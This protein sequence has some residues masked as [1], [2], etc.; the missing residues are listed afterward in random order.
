VSPVFYLVAALT[1]VRTFIPLSILPRLPQFLLPPNGPTSRQRQS[2]PTAAALSFVRD[3]E[4]FTGCS[5]ATNSLPE[6]YI[7]PYRE[8]MLNV[9][10]EGKV[11]MVVVVCG[12]HEDDEEFKRDVLCDSELV[13]TLKEKDIMVWGADVRSREGYQGEPRPATWQIRLLTDSRSDTAAY[14][15]P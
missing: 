13:R 12:E 15:I 8:F 10:K 3:L 14:D 9:R 4:T 2:N 7:G 11:G 1:L 6:F 5:A